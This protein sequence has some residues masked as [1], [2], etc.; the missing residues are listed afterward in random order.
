[1]DFNAVER[2]VEYLETDQ[3]APAITDVRTPANVSQRSKL[4]IRQFF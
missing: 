3:E 1:M 2:V 4:Y